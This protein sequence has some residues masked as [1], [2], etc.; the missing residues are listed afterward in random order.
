MAAVSVDASDVVE[1]AKQMPLFGPAIVEREIGHALVNVGEL[2]K[3]EAMLNARTIS[4]TGALKDSIRR[5]VFGTGFSRSVE[6]GVGIEYGAPVEFGTRAGYTPPLKALEL[7]VRQRGRGTAG[8]IGDDSWAEAEKVQN[9]IR[10]RGTKA[11]PFLNPAV[12]DNMTEIEAIL[13]RA[14]SVATTKI[15]KI[16]R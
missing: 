1:F 14:L 12:D 5:R 9:I 4:N 2:V 7:W 11:Q 13:D 3:R 6:V 15:A 10:R 8:G 16:G